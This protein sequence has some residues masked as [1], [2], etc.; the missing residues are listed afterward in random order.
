[1]KLTESHSIINSLLIDFDAIVDYKIGII[2]LFRKL[3]ANNINEEY[4]YLHDLDFFKLD[5]IYSTEDIVKKALSENVRDDYERLTEEFLHGEYE[6]DIYKLSTPTVVANMIRG[7]QLTGNIIKMDILCYTDKQKAF[8]NKVLPNVSTITKE[9]IDLDQYGRIILGYIKSLKL[10]ENPVMKNF[11]IVNFRENFEENDN[12]VLKA[13][14][15]L[16]IMDL[17][18]F[19]MI[20]SY[21]NLEETID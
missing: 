1:M 7:Y 21:N 14:Y 15:I 6:A 5:H 13:E 10:F 20:D 9:N 17:N 11:L 18:K 3:N 4:V 12:E 2:N 16:P 8:I 19:G